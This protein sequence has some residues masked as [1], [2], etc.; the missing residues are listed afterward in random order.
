MTETLL[1][2]DIEQTTKG[3]RH[4]HTIEVGIEIGYYTENYGADADGNRGEKRTYCESEVLSVGFLGM[5][6]TTKDGKR[7]WKERKIDI[8][9]ITD[10]KVN[11]RI[12][13]EVEDF[14]ISPEICE[15]EIGRAHV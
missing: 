5:W 10:S 11:S 1:I 13:Q 14:D 3:R 8:N 7:K 6:I 9:K 15:E 12:E 2:E 4:W